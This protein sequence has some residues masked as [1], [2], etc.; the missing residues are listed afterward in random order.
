MPG[1]NET[2]ARASV[3]RCIRGLSRQ[4]QGALFRNCSLVHTAMLMPSQNCPPETSFVRRRLGAFQVHF[5]ALLHVHR[6][7]RTSSFTD[8]EAARERSAPS[9]SRTFTHIAER[10]SKMAASAVVSK[11]AVMHVVAVVAV[12]AATARGIHLVSGTC[13]TGHAGESFVPTV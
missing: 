2:R 10:G 13:V 3:G 11:S 8:I 5:V 6:R 12:D 4:C 9:T 7:V 1:H